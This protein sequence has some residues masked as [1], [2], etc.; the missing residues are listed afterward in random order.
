[1]NLLLG[2]ALR[3]IFSSA[4]LRSLNITIFYKRS[5]ADLNCLIDCNLLILY[6]TT[7][8]IIVFTFF[9]LLPGK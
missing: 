6:E 4:D 9:D 2:P 8:Q 3:F 7:F 1:M 5:S